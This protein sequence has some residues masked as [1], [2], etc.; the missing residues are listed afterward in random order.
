VHLWPPLI[1]SGHEQA[2]VHQEVAALD[3][4]TKGWK[5]C[6]TQHVISKTSTRY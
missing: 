5:T 6:S 2:M 1:L 3:K 4:V